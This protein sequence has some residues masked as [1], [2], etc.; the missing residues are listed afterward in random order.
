VAYTEGVSVG[1]DMGEGLP[2]TRW[3]WV[4]FKAEGKHVW[5]LLPNM[6]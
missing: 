5:D 6:N 4:V 2:G 1:A 3:F